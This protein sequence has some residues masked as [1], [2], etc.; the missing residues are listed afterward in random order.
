MGDNGRIE[1]T[2]EDTLLFSE[3]IIH[4]NGPGFVKED[5]PHLFERFYR[6]KE[7]DATGYG[8]GLALCKMIIV[9]HGGTITAK[10]HPWG[11]AVFSIR[12]PK[13]VP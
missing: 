2:C 5:L 6:G 11:G 1:I 3:I 13:T 4:D 12:F 10:N 8:I 9:R 7:E